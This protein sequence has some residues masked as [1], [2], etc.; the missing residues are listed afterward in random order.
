MITLR[1][2]RHDRAEAVAVEPARHERPRP[3]LR[4][5]DDAVTKAVA[6]SA[7]ARSTGS[8]DPTRADEKRSAGGVVATLLVILLFVCV[9]GVVVFQVFLVQTQSHLDQLD[10]D[11]ATQEDLAKDLRLKT[12]D[13]EAPD[14]IVKDAKDRLGMIPP[15]DVVYL[16]PNA[17]DDGRA[18]FDAAKEAPPVAAPPT[19]APASGTPTY[20]TGTATG[21]YGTGTGTGANGAATPT[22][23][24]TPPTTAWTPPTTAWKPPTTTKSATTPTST[25]TTVPKTATTSAPKTTTTVPKSSP[26]TSRT[27]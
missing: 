23:K 17:S 24:W 15:G 26:T 1:A 16:Q 9:F 14:R 13:L 8:P 19:T 25:A 21:G 5:V 4:V 27:R 11:I 20:G 3:A 18:G 7:T 22:T 12:T 10:R 2:A 6:K